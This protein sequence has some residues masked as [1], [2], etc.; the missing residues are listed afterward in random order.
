MKSKIDIFIDGRCPD[1][2]LQNVA[3][4]FEQNDIEIDEFNI[5]KL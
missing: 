2:F 1:G 3:D 4:V 5:K